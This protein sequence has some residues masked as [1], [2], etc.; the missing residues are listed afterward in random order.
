MPKWQFDCKPHSRP[1]SRSMVC[2]SSSI[3]WL[4]EL[5]EPRWRGDGL[6]DCV[7]TVW[8]G[9]VGAVSGVDVRSM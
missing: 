9:G 6:L 7:A 5:L 4:I 2:R 3:C 1:Y 8:F